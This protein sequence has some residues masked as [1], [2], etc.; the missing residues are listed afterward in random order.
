[1]KTLEERRRSGTIDNFNS[2]EQDDKVSLSLPVDLIIEILIKL[3]SRS[4]SRLIC[5]SKLWSSIIQG[6]LFND[7]YLTPSLT[8]PLLLFQ[9][10]CGD[11]NLYQYSSSQENDPS[12]GHNINLKPIPGCPISP[13]VR[14]LICS[15]DVDAN[16]LNVCNPTTGKFLTLPR[17]DSV[18]ATSLGYDP[19]ND[20]YKVFSM[21]RVTDKHGHFVRSEHH[22][23]YSR[24]SKNIE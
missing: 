13:P 1:M 10:Y 5:V 17:V 20:L 19:I 11:T 7:L 2:K 15:R 4:V 16:V 12:S 24:S 14:G 3:P 8:R 22:V 21:K 18:E 23:F 9:F 6:K